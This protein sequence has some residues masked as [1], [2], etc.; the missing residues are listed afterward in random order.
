[1]NEKDQG[2]HGEFVPIGLGEGVPPDVAACQSGKIK[3][4][5]Y[6]TKML[7]QMEERQVTEHGKSAETFLKNRD[8]LDE[9][10]T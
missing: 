10:S 4:A 2:S 3:Y 8:S 9:P 7:K 1:M 6:R 5:K